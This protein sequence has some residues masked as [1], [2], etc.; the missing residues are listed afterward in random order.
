M[1]EKRIQF[2]NIVK[3]QVPT[4]VANDFPLISE[5]LEQYY[6]S[7][8][9]KSAPI[10]LIQ[11][12]DQ[13]I[14]LNEQTSLNHNIVLEGDIDEFATTIN[15]DVGSSPQG[16]QKFPD[17][18][19]LLKIDDE[20]ITYTGKTQYS[21]TGCIRGFVGIS[22]Y[23][24][25]SN[26]ENLVFES[27]AAAEHKDEATIENLTCSFLTEFLKKTKIQLLPGLSDRALYSGLDQNKFIKQAKDFYSS[28]GT[29]ESFKILFKA[30]YGEDIKIIRPKEYLL[31]P[32][33]GQNLVTSN[34]VVEGI[35]GDPSTLELKTVFQDY[36]AKAYTP[37]YGVEEIKVGAG[38]TYYRLSFDGG[39]NRDSRVLGAT[40]GN[41]KVSPKTHVIGN[42][43]AGST[44]IDV[45]STVGF[46]TS[47]NLFVRYPTS[48]SSPTGIVSYT[49]KTLTQFLGC[50]NIDDTIVDG[51]SI[52]ISSFV[53][54]KPYTDDL[55]VEV[56]VGSVLT[57]FSKPEEVH[58]FK[59]ED[60]F[61][62]KSIGVKNT[63]FKFK[64]WIYSN[65]VL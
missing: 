27:T 37:I 63:G 47:G 14:S 32:S 19:G 26:P 45:D 44:Y 48:T 2:S 49:S 33:N 13:Y 1:T 15:V 41:F 20:I 22:S 5:F 18:Y 3:S 24:S 4:Y 58:D 28:K 65:P 50:T 61:K 54:N 23:K 55:G 30:L 17:T 40:Y 31:T 43:S 62:V 56:R 34:F 51:D 39:Y 7:Q 59:V 46:E 10:D 42:V 9:F 29:D 8:E 64:N 60:N 25:D 21:F 6:L 52:G 11:N 16:T 36:P 35:S 57:G 12:I 38:K 53:Y